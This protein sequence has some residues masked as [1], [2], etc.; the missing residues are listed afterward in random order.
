[1]HFSVVPFTVAVTLQFPLPTAVTVPSAPTVATEVLLL[2]QVTAALVPDTTIRKVSPA[3][4]RVKSSRLSFVRR[5]KRMRGA[6]GRG[7][8]CGGRCPAALKIAADDTGL[9][10]CARHRCG[11]SDR[12]R[13]HRGNHPVPGDGGHIG[14]AGLPG[15]IPRGPFRINVAFIWNTCP[16]ASK[17]KSSRLRVNPVAVPTPEMSSGGRR[18]TFGGRRALDGRLTP[19]GCAALCRSLGRNAALH[20]GRGRRGRVASTPP[21]MDLTMGSQYRPPP[22]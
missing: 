3:C 13:R 6:G 21:S 22:R 1:M 2:A 12:P 18:L 5:R 15:D 17:V 19:G 16:A 4:P 11:E 10:S 8:S 9:F 20:R 14:I 7:S